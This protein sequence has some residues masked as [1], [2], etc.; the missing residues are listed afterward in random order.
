MKAVFFDSDMQDSAN[1]RFDLAVRLLFAILFVV[2]LPS[3]ARP[4]DWPGAWLDSAP[5]QWNQPGVSLPKLPQDLKRNIAPD[6]C[7]AY[8]PAVNSQE[9]RA[10][11][12][13][14]W[15][16]VAS[17]QGG[18]RITVVVGAGGEDGMCRPDPYENFV[19]VRGEF[20]GTLS[21][22]LMRARADGSVNKVEFGGPR[23]IM[24]YFSRYT[25]SDPLCCPSRVSQATYEIRERSG[26]PVLVLVGVRTRPT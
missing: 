23:R 19:F 16:V 11:A 18:N 24:A 22:Q 8:E 17:S 4:E 26:K 15:I 9:E 13:A 25:D 12:E 3:A 5:V 21:P 6:Y 14:G 7:K 2:L 10:V 20:A 1:G